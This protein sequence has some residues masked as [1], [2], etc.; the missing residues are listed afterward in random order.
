MQRTHD[1]YSGHLASVWEYSRQYMHAFRSI[2]VLCGVLLLATSPAFGEVI[3]EGFD[4]NPHGEN[5]PT[6][7]VLGKATSTAAQETVQRAAA[8]NFAW[9]AYCQ[10]GSISR[11]AAASGGATQPQRWI[12]LA[13][14]ALTTSLVFDRGCFAEGNYAYTRFDSNAA[15]GNNNVPDREID[16]SSDQSH[17]SVSV[18]V[19]KTGV[20]GVRHAALWGSVVVFRTNQSGRLSVWQRL[21]H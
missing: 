14:R 10:P 13:S 4:I 18:Y 5:P 12:G 20:P 1:H 19:N 2:A 11:P 3:A 8:S 9:G 17:V 21:Q 6:F 16:V 7:Y 15:D